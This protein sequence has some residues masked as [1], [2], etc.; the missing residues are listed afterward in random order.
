ML[1]TSGES[2]CTL[3]GLD[4]DASRCVGPLKSYF[5]PVLLHFNLNTS[6]I[7]KYAG[8]TSFIINLICIKKETFWMKCSNIKCVLNVISEA[9]KINS[10]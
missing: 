10:Y 7:I 9:D 3:R 2:G 4:V 5:V 6:I 1:K 8:I